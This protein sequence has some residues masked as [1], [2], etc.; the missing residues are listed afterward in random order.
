MRLDIRG[1]AFNVFNR[2]RFGTGS[3]T[4]QS[5]QFGQLTSSGD[6]LNTPRQLQVALKFYW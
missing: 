1:E 5:A 6:L 4:V 2:H 3:L